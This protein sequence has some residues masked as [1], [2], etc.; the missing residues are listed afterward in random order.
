MKKIGFFYF[1]NVVNIINCLFILITLIIN[2]II[3]N[4]I[5]RGVPFQKI[6]AGR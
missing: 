3:F 2:V 6:E 1:L 4:F 5:K